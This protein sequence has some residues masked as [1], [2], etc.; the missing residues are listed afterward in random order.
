MKKMEKEVVID[1]ITKNSDERPRNDRKRIYRAS[2]G[3]HIHGFEAAEANN[4]NE[5][6][7]NYGR[8][9]NRGNGVGINRGSGSGQGQRINQGQDRGVGNHINNGRRD[10][11]GPHHDSDGCNIKPE[12]STNPDDRGH[13]YLN[14]R[15]NLGYRKNSVETKLF[16]D[17]EELV[18]Y[19]NNRKADNSE[20]EIYKIEDGLYK[21]VIRS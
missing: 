7:R 15:T 21:L 4:E 9:P 11:E 17:K 2:G 8:R 6:S 19:V 18:K 14:K 10:G 5:Y 3:R 13:R 20:V 1:E 16:T 12:R